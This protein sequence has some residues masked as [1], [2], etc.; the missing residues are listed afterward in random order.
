MCIKQPTV[1]T[2]DVYSPVHNVFDA[3][4]SLTRGSGR[5]LGPGILEF[6]GPQIALAHR[7][8]VISQGPKNPRIPGP[9]PLPFPLVINI[10]GWGGD[11][12]CVCV[13]VCTIVNNEEEQTIAT[14]GMYRDDQSLFSFLCPLYCVSAYGCQDPERFHKRV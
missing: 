10:G 11:R 9:N 8:D 6:F 12:N 14:P 7:L 2:Y 13:T 1:C 4:I 5:G 3:C